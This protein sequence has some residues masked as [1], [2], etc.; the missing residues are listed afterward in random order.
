[1]S[2]YGRKQTQ[3]MVAR[4]H[5]QV[6][7][8]RE[9]LGSLD[10]LYFAFP[11][12]MAD[13]ASNYSDPVVFIASA[14]A[15]SR[16]APNPQVRKVVDQRHPLPSAYI[17]LNGITDVEMTVPTKNAKKLLKNKQC[18]VVEKW[19]S[20]FVC[21]VPDQI[22]DAIDRQTAGIACIPPEGTVWSVPVVN[23]LQEVSRSISAQ[24]ES[25]DDLPLG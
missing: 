24:K 18:L 9:Q 20:R 25:I 2:R 23:K 19:G 10:H 17:E 16:Q 6:E 3:V 4:A 1:M 7:E 8:L 5:D 15:L 12:V 13:G 21:R 14:I 22:R 11:Q